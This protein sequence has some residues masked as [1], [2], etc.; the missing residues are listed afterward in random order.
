M[1]DRRDDRVE[2]I[3]VVRDQQQRSRVA[4]QPLLEPEH[5][6][7]IEMVGRLVEQEQVRARHQRL[8]QVEPHAPA[9][10]EACDRIAMTRRGESEAREQARGAGA[11]AVTG[12]R[13]VALMQLRE[14][15]PG[16][17]RMGFGVS[18]RALYGAELHVAVEHE[19]DRGGRHGRLL[20]RN[21]GDHPRWRQGHLA[22][23]GIDLAAKQREQR[24]L[25]A[26]VGADQPHP[27]SGV[28]GQRRVFEQALVAASQCK[29]AYSDQRNS[30]S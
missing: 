25:A 21:M 6:I 14:M 20:L 24:R 17:A 27:V 28:H 2:K 26:A 8:R 4:L 29:L 23:F 16:S 1:D 15:L 13:L 18:Q 7:E 10:G 19:F 5:G 11:G 30:K 3:A 12:D 9:A 22:R